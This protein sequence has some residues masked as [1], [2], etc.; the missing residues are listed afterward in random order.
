MSF[1]RRVQ[2]AQPGLNPRAFKEQLLH[3]CVQ[4]HYIVFSVHLSLFVKKGKGK[5]VC[6]FALQF[7]W[8]QFFKAPPSPSVIQLKLFQLHFTNAFKI[9]SLKLLST[10]PF[11]LNQLQFLNDKNI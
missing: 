5:S 10:K 6:K 3:V 9:E 4:V 7:I 11:F 8:G 1:K 2:T